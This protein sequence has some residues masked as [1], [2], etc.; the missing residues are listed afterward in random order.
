MLLRSNPER[1]IMESSLNSR[2]P[3]D[4]MASARKFFRDIFPV[5][6]Q[7]ALRLDTK[8]FVS[9]Y[10]ACLKEAY[11]A[12]QPFGEVPQQV[13]IILFLKRC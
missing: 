4:L 13:I 7:N 8:Q 10:E 3:K 5:A 2:P 1:D 11:D 9:E 12:V 6:Y